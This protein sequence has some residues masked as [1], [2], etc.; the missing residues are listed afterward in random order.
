LLSLALKN[1]LALTEV[2][3]EALVIIIETIISTKI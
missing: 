1:P 2:N 3:R